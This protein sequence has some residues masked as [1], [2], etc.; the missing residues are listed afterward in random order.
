[1]A[2][3]DR[4]IDCF[5]LTDVAQFVRISDAIPLSLTR[6]VTTDT[7]TYYVVRT[8][9]VRISW[10]EAQHYWN[11]PVTVGKRTAAGWP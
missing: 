8:R 9:E 2:G 7:R 1:M 10:E 3:V 11:K 4:R 5:L 6:T